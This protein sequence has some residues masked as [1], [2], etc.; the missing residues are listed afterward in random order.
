MVL[1][2]ASAQQGTE[3]LE[4]HVIRRWE[5]VARSRRVAH[6]QSRAYKRA[7]TLHMWLFMTIGTWLFTKLRGELVGS[8]AQ[9]NRYYQDKRLI[10]G[11][12]R[13]RWVMYN[14]VPEA[15]RVPPDWYGWLHHTTD[16]VPPPGGLPR[17]VWE[18]P[19]VPNTTG[20]DQA[21]RPPGHTLGVG[22]KPKPSYEAWRP[23]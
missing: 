5:A 20:T 17:Q 10:P 11:R 9:G 13:K 4:S 18:K 23:S 21:F 19:H 15:T 3:S 6:L 1:D 22:E 2:D 12:R 16:K 8:D 14:G 7:V